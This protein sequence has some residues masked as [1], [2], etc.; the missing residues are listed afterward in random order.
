MGRKVGLC[1]LGVPL[2]TRMT[3]QENCFM[4]INQ[5]FQVVNGSLFYDGKAVGDTET[6][7]G[8]RY[9]EFENEPLG[10]GANGLTY[11]AHHTVLGVAQVIKLYFPGENGEVEKARLEA[12]KN[13]DPRVRDVAAQVHDAG[14]YMYPREISYSIMESVSDIQTLSEWL[15]NRDTEWNFFKAVID[16]SE[17]SEAKNAA[18][19][20]RA[21]RFALAD[22]L[23]VAAGFIG[24]V[25]RLS[26]AG[27]THGDLN[28][29]NILVSLANNDPGWAECSI[30][31]PLGKKKSI[32]RDDEFELARSLRCR[33]G[34]G[35][36]NLLNPGI[37]KP[38]N[39]KLIDLGTSQE[40]GTSPSVGR[41]RERF[42]LI[43][44]L[45]KIL[46]PFFDGS[47]TFDDYF[48]FSL[49]ERSDL[50][51]VANDVLEDDDTG[52]ETL[53]HDLF[54]LLSLLNLLVGHA[55]NNRTRK[56]DEPNAETGLHVS[57]VQLVNILLSADVR[58]LRD[59]IFALDVLPIFSEFGEEINNELI[60]WAA[61][62]SHWT[63][64]HPMF[65]NHQLLKPSV[66]Q[67]G[68]LLVSRSK[69][70]QRSLRPSI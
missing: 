8:F 22:A 62:W 13:A 9:F 48:L 55:H 57:D 11:R 43:D 28:P 3:D 36:E 67:P 38:T 6:R 50:E 54:R 58:E 64:L 60:D 5:G 17:L 27:V 10:N 18:A 7:S 14:V 66:F 23:N 35:N 70:Q 44:N 1:I 29:Q 61:V 31:F 34:Y 4:Q 53:A 68:W 37:L 49:P 41:A 16:E 24:A 21:A 59:P 30:H 39:V 33:F 25:V 12:K 56:D 32:L 52:A 46:R 2:P 51:M 19:K 63:A 45:R 26:S 20:A 42:F 15:K 69:Q 47:K 40:A 65:S